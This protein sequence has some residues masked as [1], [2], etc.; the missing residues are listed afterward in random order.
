LYVFR[1]AA[2]PKPLSAKSMILPVAMPRTKKQQVIT[3]N[4]GWKSERHPVRLNTRCQPETPRNSVAIKPKRTPN[5]R[6]AQTKKKGRVRMP[7]TVDGTVTASRVGPSSQML[8][9]RR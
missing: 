4:S 9:A 7:A 3:M 5:M 8:I 2:N 6:R 1:L